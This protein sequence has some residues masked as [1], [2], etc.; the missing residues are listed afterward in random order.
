M[1]AVAVIPARSGSTRVKNKNFRE[2]RFGSLVEIALKDAQAAGFFSEI[3]LSTDS[4]SGKYLAEIYSATFHQRSVEASSDTATAT[5]VL[6]DLKVCFKEIGV[7]PDDFLF[8]LQP[9][10][11]FRT[12]ALLRYAWNDICAAQRLGLV[13]VS[14]VDSKYAKLMVVT[15]GD[16]SPVMGEEVATANQ[17]AGKQVFLANG[18]IFAFRWG[19]FLHRSVF[20]LSGLRALVQGEVDS[21]DIDSETDFELFEKSYVP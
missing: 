11:P 19:H 13:T 6:L 21:L 3:I 17:Q 9:T 20:P 5:D 12:P 14:P 2:S 1:R 8:Y 10:S 16:V 4:D 15:N 7:R 18:N